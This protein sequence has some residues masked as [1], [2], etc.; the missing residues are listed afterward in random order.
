MISDEI[1]K[2]RE[3]GTPGPWHIGSNNPSRV[4]DLAGNPVIQRDPSFRDAER[5]EANAR[6]IARVPELEEAYLALTAENAELK[7]W[8]A[9]LEAALKFYA[10]PDLN[11]YEIHV[12]NYGLSTEEGH[13]I[14][15]AG[16]KARAVRKA[17]G[18]E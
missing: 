11:G 12:T 3:T 18:Y 5:C 2:D 7:K 10:D 15:D 17:L 16:D 4:F 6:R 1:Q 13:I 9:E 8:V 14:K